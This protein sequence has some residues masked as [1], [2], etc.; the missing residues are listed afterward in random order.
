MST[1]QPGN[2]ISVKCAVT[3]APVPQQSWVPIVTDH[4]CHPGWTLTES[5]GNIWMI[6][7]TR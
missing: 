4:G 5:T 1:W 2:L 3:C 6:D 7:S